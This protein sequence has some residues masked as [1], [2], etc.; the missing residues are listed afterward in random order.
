MRIL[1][2]GSCGKK[3]LIQSIT[4]PTCK[5]LASI[6]DVKTWREI[7]SYLT[8]RVR[9]LYT[10]NQ[11]RE[12]V[13]GVDLLRQIE[14][15]KVKLYIISAG[16]GLVEE[17]E[18]LPTYDCSFS[19]M[20]KLQIQERAKW[21]NIPSDFEKLVTS[22]F[23][24]VYLA[25]GKKYFLTLG[26]EWKNKSNTTMIGFNQDLSD[27]TMLCIPSSHEIVSAFS[28]HG[29]KIHG[30]TGFKGDLLRILADYALEQK[31]SYSELVAWTHPEYLHDLV[32]KLGNLE[33]WH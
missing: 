11:N 23:D 31:N 21:L 22:D 9:D 32:M 8:T 24:L 29:H 5:D 15:T 27:A 16:F 13:R 4:S 19:G 6:G 18:K 7:S 33:I 2:V 3:K 12:L 26:E 28:R 20:R 30:V 25:L 10:G 1:V 14:K 17:K